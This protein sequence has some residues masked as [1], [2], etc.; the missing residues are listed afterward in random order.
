MTKMV[1]CPKCG[2]LVSMTMLLSI[3][4]DFGCPNCATQFSRF[5]EI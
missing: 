1:K 5:E 3:R 4:F 2:F